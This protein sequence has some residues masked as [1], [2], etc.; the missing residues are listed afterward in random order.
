ALFRAG[1]TVS[2]K[3]YFRTSDRD[4]LHVP[5]TGRPD[6][7]VIQRQG[8]SQQ[9]EMALEWEETPGG[10][11]VALNEFALPESAYLGTYSVR[12]TDRDHGWY[13]DQEFRV[14]EFRLPVMTGQISVSDIQQGVLVA[15]EA[16]DVDV[17]LSWMT[18]G[19]AAGQKV[20][21]SAVATE[22]PPVI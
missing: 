15:P 5:R 16:M 7:V 21:L 3:H 6:R 14:E 13:G 12:L 17:Q 20:A 22:R 10:G 4:G 11:L 9:Y 19:P 8:S 2:M 1:E 18:G